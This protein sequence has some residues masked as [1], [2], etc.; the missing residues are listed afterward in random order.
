ML[1]SETEM[2]PTRVEEKQRGFNQK[3]QPLDNILDAT[4]P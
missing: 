2:T 1:P 3:T 4:I